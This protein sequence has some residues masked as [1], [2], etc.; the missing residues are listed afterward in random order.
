MMTAT[1]F[2]VIKHLQENVGRKNHQM[3]TT[4]KEQEMLQAPN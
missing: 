1:I 4:L 3:P 2:S